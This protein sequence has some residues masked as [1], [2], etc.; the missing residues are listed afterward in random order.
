[1][2]DFTVRPFAFMRLTH[3]ALRAGFAEVRA[4]IAAGSAPAEV[5]ETYGALRRALELHAAQ[6]EQV[7][8]PVLDERCGGAVREAGLRDAHERE[9]AHQLAF[10]AALAEGEQR[11]MA[12]T[13]E[14]WAPSFEAHLADEEAIMMPLTHKT[15][16][17][18][19]GRALVVRRIMETDWEALKR[20]QLGYVVASLSRTKPFGP[21]RMYVA[22]VQVAAGSAYGE[23]EPIV[24]AALPA[25][26]LQ[27]LTSL[28]H[29]AE[30]A[31]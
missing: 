12:A 29:L 28:G 27:K 10:E 26:Q 13:I 24:R 8:F 3:D 5:R 20:D 21:L 22:A 1:M 6:E 11:A 19:E 15:A 9:E 14:A 2:T 4:A 31:A 23:L 25:E 16:D 7:F 17:T 18:A 30:R